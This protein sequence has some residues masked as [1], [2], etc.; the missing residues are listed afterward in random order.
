MARMSVSRKV[1]F[2]KVRTFL[3]SIARNSLKTKYAYEMGLKHLQRF[4]IGSTHQVYNVE[5]IPQPLQTGTINAYELIDGFVSYLVSL[6]Q[7]ANGVRSNCICTIR[8]SDDLPPP[9]GLEY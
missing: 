3:E 6:R 9:K 4:L 2:L 8:I 5:T 1:D 7:G